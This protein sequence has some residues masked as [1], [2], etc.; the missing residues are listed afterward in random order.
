MEAK[1]SAKSKPNANAKPDNS[2]TAAAGE[3]T[4][5]VIAKPTL[6]KLDIAAAP[7]YQDAAKEIDNLSENDAAAK[8]VDNGPLGESRGKDVWQLHAQLKALNQVSSQVERHGAALQASLAELDQHLHKDTV[9]TTKLVDH[10]GE[11]LASQV[12]DFQDSVEN[13]TTSSKNHL[14]KHV[15]DA[16]KAI[17]LAIAKTKDTLS[18]EVSDTKDTLNEAVS[19]TQST[20]SKNVKDGVTDLQGRLDNLLQT[21]KDSFAKLAKA[22]AGTEENLRT[23][24]NA[25]SQAVEGLMGTL[26]TDLEKQIT[27]FR[28]ESTRQIDK[29]FNQSDVAFAAVR[30]DQ[31]VIK[32]LLTDI[33]KD[34][35]GR[36]EPKIR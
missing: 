26:Q 23:Q 10:H 34:R 9:A 27:E 5:I 3:G 30:A 2:K 13:W 7:V 28:D 16:E 24:T 20:L 36:A 6:G 1:L 21:V 22:T 8:K 11:S 35:M 14:T 15:S 33:I 25:F 19:K 12:S 32:A 29:R 4:V 31:E 17:T 18:G